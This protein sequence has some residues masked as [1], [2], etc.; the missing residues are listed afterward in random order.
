MPTNPKKKVV[1]K[2]AS[3]PAP[4]PVQ[5]EGAPVRDSLGGTA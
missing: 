3:Q 1:A 5:D 4:Q 2:P